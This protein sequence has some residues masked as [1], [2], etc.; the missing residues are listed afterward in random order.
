[1]TSFKYVDLT[2]FENPYSFDNDLPHPTW[3]PVSD[4]IHNAFHETAWSEAWGEAVAQWLQKLA[5]VL[6]PTYQ[7]DQSPKFFTMS[8]RDEK[9]RKQLMQLAE[10]LRGEI[11][12]ALKGIEL[13]KTYGKQVVLLF[14]DP[15]DYYRYISHYYAEGTH[16]QSLGKFIT[17]SGYAH[18]VLPDI[19]Y[20]TNRTLA[21]ELTH[22]CLMTLRIPLWLNEG[23]A[24][25]IA[26]QFSSYGEK[27]LTADLADQHF[28]FWTREKIQ[29]FWDGR[30]FSYP[31]YSAMAYSLS[32]ILVG[33]ITQE[34]WD[35]K[36][37]IQ[38]ASY[39]DAGAKAA[40]EYL[41]RTLSEIAGIFLGPGNW[42]PNP[43]QP[44]TAK[45]SNP[46]PDGTNRK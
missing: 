14:G 15:T 23:L 46:S 18:I 43:P 8:C 16:I 19:P 32:T 2:R 28:S 6:G 29:S 13:K 11:L 42:S 20:Q 41:G 38:H 44:T 5:A 4:Y 37:F 17:S 22:N 33:L 3:K 31:A 45:V 36:N 12:T 39:T 30:A 9:G 24:N 35:I 34:N 25:R 10:Q 27:C 21:H 26:A 7:V 1:M 40:E